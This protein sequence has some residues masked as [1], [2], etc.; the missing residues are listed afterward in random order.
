[1]I[2]LAFFRENKKKCATAILRTICVLF[3][4]KTERK[5]GEYTE[6]KKI[7][8]LCAFLSKTVISN[9]IFQLFDTTT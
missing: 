7:L 6:K 8:L 1:M 5:A 3:L 9:E 2:Y 4:Y